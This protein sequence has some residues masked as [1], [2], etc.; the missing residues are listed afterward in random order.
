MQIVI[1]SQWFPPEQA[2]FGRMMYE[3]AHDLRDAGCQVTVITGYPNHPSGVVFEGYKKKLMS[4]ENDSGVRILRVWLRTSRNRSTLER[5]LTFATFSLSAALALKRRTQPDVVF[6][7]LQPLSIGMILPF[8]ARSKRA[9]LVVN[10]QDLHPDTQ[11]KLGLVKNRWLVRALRAIERYSYKASDHISVICEPFRQHCIRVGANPAKV[12]VIENWIDVSE[13]APV[14]RDNDFRRACE[15]SRD[16]FVVLWAG[17]LGHV[18]GAE[19]ILSVAEL[20]ADE[21][22]VRFLVVGEGPLRERMISQADEMK[23]RNV[24]FKP[25][26]PRD[27]LSLVQ[28]SGDVSLVTLGA[29]FANSS[30]PSKVLGYMSAAR[31]IVAAV[32]EVSETARFLRSAECARIVAEDPTSIAVAIRELASARELAATMGQKGREYVVRHR[33]RAAQAEQYRIL[34]AAVA[35]KS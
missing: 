14:P 18:S 23:L 33:S 21:P 12:S 3:L 6:A 25:F 9:K 7:V 15:L 19:K 27:M 2:P 34:F 4:E 28:G 13:I 26:Q 29:E 17:T 11:I 1:V 22:H 20:L 5:L 30:V 35:Q 10:L 16:D 8:I 24:V 31:P 32:P